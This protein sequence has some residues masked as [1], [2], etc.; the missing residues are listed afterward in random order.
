MLGKS[1]AAGA[2]L[3]LACLSVLALGCG[4]TSP[5]EPGTT[6]PTEPAEDALATAL[7]P[8]QSP[9]YYVDQAHKY[10]DALD[11]SADPAN[12][13]SYST[14]VARW[15]LPPW[16]W[17]TGYGREN[18]IQTTELAVALGPS[19]VPTRD[20]RAFDVQPFARCYIT[21]EYAEGPCPIYEEFVFN[22]QGEITFIE[23]WSDQPEFLPISDP[24]DP[25][26]EG[27][28][29]PRLSTKVPGLGNETGLID[30]SSDA[31]QK[32]ADEDPEVADFVRRAEDFWPAWRE[33]A[34]EAGTDYYPRGCGWVQ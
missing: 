7:T 3:G 22:D 13:P 26:M 19:T 4:S 24:D 33:A 11:T 16:L 27:P 12:V 20:C 17:L 29:V 28:D 2:L 15:E 31:M 1:R 32:A 6:P 10:F 14:L 34:D 5:S 25:W 8:T 30:L 21:F 18:M 9:E 23:A